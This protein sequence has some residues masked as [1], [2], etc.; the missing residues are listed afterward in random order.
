MGA[1]LKE[2]IRRK[3]AE[4]DIPLVGF[5][6]ADRWDTPLFDP[7]IPAAFCPR[8]IFKETSTVIV[9]GLPV[10]LPVLDTA[11][12]IWYHE[13]YRTINALLDQNGYRIAAELTRRGYP[14][15][16]VPRDGYGSIAVLKERP[17]AFFSHRHAAYLAGLGTFGINNTLLTPEFGP[18]VRFASIFTTAEIPPDPVMEKD[19]CIR[20]MRCVEAC[21]VN[22]LGEDMYPQ[23][24]TDKIAC[25]TRAED[26]N[27]RFLSPCGLCIRACP[28]GHDRDPYPREDI[29]RYNESDDAFASYHRAWNHVRAYGSR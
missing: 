25:A 21:P 17:V 12:S 16:P 28:V 29:N 27:R 19:L 20:C 22:A 2:E 14:S 9:I 7:W 5:A 13:H 6:P 3:C 11:P 26:L 18:R 15:L 24:L 4:L 8:A 1:E 23:G 10:S